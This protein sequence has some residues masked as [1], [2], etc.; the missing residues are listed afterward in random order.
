VELAGTQ[1]YLTGTGVELVGTGDGALHNLQ[2]MLQVQEDWKNNKAA[3][4]APIPM[5]LKPRTPSLREMFGALRDSLQSGDLVEDMKPQ[6]AMDCFDAA[7]VVFTE[8]AG[9]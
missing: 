9:G 3:F 6:Q 2:I 8:T 4:I 7:K 1:V 5:E